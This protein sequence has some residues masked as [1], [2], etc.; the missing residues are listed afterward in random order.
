MT[1]WNTVIQGNKAVSWKT[2]SRSCV[3]PAMF[4]PSTVMRP[5]VGRS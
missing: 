2:T 4:C 1:F 3:G 5:S